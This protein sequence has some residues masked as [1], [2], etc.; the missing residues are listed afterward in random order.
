MVWGVDT[1]E[2]LDAM[3][4]VGF[5]HVIDNT[6]QSLT[7]LGERFDLIMDMKRSSR[8][9]VR[10]VAPWSRYVTVGGD[11]VRSIRLLFARLFGQRSVHIVALKSNKNLDT[12]ALL[13]GNGTLKPVIDGPYVLKDAPSF[14][15]YFGEGRHTGKVVMEL[16]RSS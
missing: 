10:A 11:P 12:L 4:A 2:K 7:Q 9:L 5:D 8:E 15:R 6:Q 16:D 13:I 3:K 14:I 1:G